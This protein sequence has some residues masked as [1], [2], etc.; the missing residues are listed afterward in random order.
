MDNE[1]W[2]RIALEEAAQALEEGEIPV[3]A[4]IVRGEKLLSRAHNRTLR[5]K[6]PTAHAEILALRAA[7]AVYGDWRLSDCAMYVTVEPCPMCAGALVWSRIKTLYIGT[8]NTKAGAC[9]TL[10]N[11]VQD[12]RLN[13]RLTVERGI[14]QTECAAYMK[15]FF[16]EARKKEP[17][18]RRSHTNEEDRA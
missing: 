4:V 11:I 5:A 12:E 9:G 7:A 6:D 16:R 8:D 10:M 14:L 3:G 2:M 1:S 13:H 17:Y 18:H 15:S